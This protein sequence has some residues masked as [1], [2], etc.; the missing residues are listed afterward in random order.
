M[1]VKGR[2]DRLIIVDLEAFGFFLSNVLEGNAFVGLLVST[3]LS[4]LFDSWLSAEYLFF[5]LILKVVGWEV[6]VD[7]CTVLF[8]LGGGGKS[9]YKIIS[10]QC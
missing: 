3:V 9:S 10:H 8:F 2:L 1:S 4:G 6:R 7:D 5:V